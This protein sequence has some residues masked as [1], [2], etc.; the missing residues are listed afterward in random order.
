VQNQTVARRYATAVFNLAGKSDAVAKVGSDLASI[1]ATIFGSESVRR[2]FLS[3]VFER[4]QKE[5]LLAQAFASRADDIALHATL[6]LV[7]KRREALLPSIV[8]EYQKLALA[9]ARKEPLEIVSA[10]DLAPGELEGIVSRL[11]RSYGKAFDVTARTD[12]SLLGG[13]RITMGDLRIDGS[14]A[15]RLDDIARELLTR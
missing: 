13:V 1:S 6:L 11:G 14:L 3:P 12:P 5:S 9:A 10:R 4:K 15:G 7:R 2:F 8:I